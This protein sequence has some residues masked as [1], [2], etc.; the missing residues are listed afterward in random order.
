MT[1][2]S[3]HFDNISYFKAIRG[4]QNK[5]HSTN[6]QVRRWRFSWALRTAIGGGDGE[7]TW[8][9]KFLQLDCRI[10]GY[11][12]F[13]WTF[14]VLHNPTYHTLHQSQ[15]IHI[16]SSIS[17]SLDLRLS[18][19]KWKWYTLGSHIIVVSVYLFLW[20]MKRSIRYG[21]RGND[22]FLINQTWCWIWQPGKKHSVYKISTPHAL[23]E[24]AR[25]CNCE[26][27]YLYE[28]A[29]AV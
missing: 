29:N 21:Y 26:L 2:T 9:E 17:Q 27:Q 14:G 25:N 23:S 18:C 11:C 19:L 4:H 7:R 5:C 24:K 16:G 8:R 12:L 28:I 1:F 3:H 13:N 22:K 6:F 15:H 10:Y 20:C